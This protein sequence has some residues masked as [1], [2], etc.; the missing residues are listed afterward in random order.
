MEKGFATLHFSII[1][2][3]LRVGVVHILYFLA[4][5]QVFCCLEKFFITNNVRRKLSYLHHFNLGPNDI[6]EVEKTSI[7]VPQYISQSRMCAPYPAL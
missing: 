1:L 3:S 5:M 6:R 2:F 4:R 7:S